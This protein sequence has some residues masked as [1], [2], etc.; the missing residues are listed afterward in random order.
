VR[1]DQ[2]DSP[3]EALS[4]VWALLRF[5]RATTEGLAEKWRLGLILVLK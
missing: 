1:I 5:D 3:S 2:G 4:K